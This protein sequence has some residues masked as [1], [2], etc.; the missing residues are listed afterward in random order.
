MK[1]IVRWSYVLP[2]LIAVALI[3]MLLE[4]CLP[5]LL[6]WSFIQSGQTLVGAKVEMNQVQTSILGMRTVLYDIAVA[7]PNEEFRNLFEADDIELDIE[8][9]SLL[10]RRFVIRSGRI[11]G[12]QFGTRRKTSGI[13]DA[14]LERSKPSYVESWARRAIQANAK[15][16]DAWLDDIPAN[17]E[18]NLCRDLKS[19]NLVKDFTT[20]WPAEYERFEQQA[21]M[22]RSRGKQLE[23]QFR[24]IRDNPL[25]YAAELSN[26]L[27]KVHA[28]RCDTETFISA[29][30]QLQ[31]QLEADHQAIEEAKQHDLAWIRD[32]LKFGYLEPEVLSEY[33]LGQE[34]AGRIGAVVRW[35]QFARHLA[36]RKKLEPIRSRGSDI[37]FSR[38][39]SHPDYLIR[40][41]AVEGSGHLSGHSEPIHLVGTVVGLTTQPKRYGRPT[42]V[43]LATS[44]AAKIRME[45]S[46]DRTG[47]EPL[48]HFTVDCRNLRL[49]A[50]TLGDDQLLILDMASSMA[51]LEAELTLRG[52]SLDGTLHL[53]QDQIRLTPHVAQRLGGQAADSMI[54]AGLGNI[55]NISVAIQLSGT[56]SEPSW[57]IESN[58]GSELVASIGNMWHQELIRRR[59]RWIAQFQNEMD[60]QVANS[61][62]QLRTRRMALL[63]SLQTD[64]ADL[65]AI[66]TD[67]AHRAGLPVNSLSRSLGEWIAR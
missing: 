27:A 2:R 21:R 59:D 22:L 25:R 58:L 10:K 28:L 17:L 7:D 56:L 60:S 50:S 42:R 30:Q 64:Q 34:M 11:R 31:P 65:A 44:G 6:K 51:R 9:S 45:A 39:Q 19:P 35:V 29:L 62:E 54:T 33:L 36:C 49:P 14:S 63:T 16:I 46:F 24:D 38:S 15:Q 53:V 37:L 20:R 67:S 4:Y 43:K 41:L 66:V 18:H 61:I 8:A 12:L 32:R 3:W 52:D 23:H 47:K 26:L 1:R 55:H 5:Q 40:S 48:D 13:I 57:N